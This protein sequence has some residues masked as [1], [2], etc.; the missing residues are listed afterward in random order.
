MSEIQQ[1]SAKQ[2]A[3]DLTNRKFAPGMP[4]KEAKAKGLISSVG[5]RNNYSQ[6][7][8]IYLQWRDFN[9][10]PPGE[11]D[12]KTQIISYLEERA[13]VIKQ[14]PLNQAKQALQIVLGIRLPLV[15][16]EIETILRTRSYTR[17]E[18]ERIVEHQRHRNAL[19][20][21]CAYAAGLRAHELATL[22]RANELSATPGR[23]WDSRRF[24]GLS[25]YRIYVVTGKGG[26]QREVA[27]PISLAVALE[28]L[29]LDEPKHVVDRG[30]FYKTHYD[31]GFGQALSQSFTTASKKSI[32]YS[33]GAHGL[34]HSYAKNRTSCLM[35]MGFS[36]AEAQ[37]IVSQ[38]LG[39]FRPDITIAY[40][41]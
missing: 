24:R 16:S 41:R 33:R 26:L 7:V 14:K 11:Q 17:E 23:D 13:E 2:R 39:H 40:Y 3:D 32:G 5:S 19:A 18:F 34:R 1:N 21:C 30:I 20:T 31:I 9:G 25:N 12:N 8:K 27:I 22:R 15:R 36:F 28:L 37:L 35:S 38:E 10:L 4:R 6:C 29:R